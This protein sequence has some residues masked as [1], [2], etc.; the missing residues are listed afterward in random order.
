MTDEP[1]S[2][3]DALAST[4]DNLQK[5]I[6]HVPAEVREK[7]TRE[8][9][10]FAH[11]QNES[12]IKDLLTDSRAPQSQLNNLNIESTG[13]WISAENKDTDIIDKSLGPSHIRRMQETGGLI[14]CNW[15]SYRQ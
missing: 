8:A 5:A 9:E 4:L 2:A 14:E 12:R 6:L 3:A 1:K 7:R 11:R 13:D 10:Q 15:P